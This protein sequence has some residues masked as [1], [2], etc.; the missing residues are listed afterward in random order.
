MKNYLQTIGLH[1]AV[2]VRRAITVLLLL[3]AGFM[4]PGLVKASDFLVMGW[5][6]INY[7]NNLSL[8]G[9]GGSAVVTIKWSGW[10]L[11]T[12]SH[13]TGNPNYICGFYSNQYYRNWF[14]FDIPTGLGTITSATLNVVQYGGIP[15]SGYVTIQFYDVTTPYATVNTNYSGGSA[16]GQAIFADLGTGAYFGNGLIDNSLPQSNMVSLPLNAAA[17][18]SIQNAAGTTWMVA[19]RADNISPT[20]PPDAVT[21]SATNVTGSSATFNGSVNANGTSTATYFRYGTVSGSLGTEVTASP[22]TVTGSSA[23]AISY[24][25]TGLAAGTTYYYQVKAYAASISSTVY[26]LEKSFTT[27]NSTPPAP[28]S[29]ISV[30]A[31]PICNGGG[32]TLT[33]NGPVGT[34]YWY[35]GGT[36]GG[37]SIGQGNTLT[38]YPTTT[39]TYSAMN[40]NNSLFS[41]CTASAAVVVNNP[42]TVPATATCGSV[43]NTTAALSWGTSTATGAITYYWVVGTSSSVTYGTVGVAGVAAQGTT[44][45][46][47]TTATATGLSPST[48]Y[49]LRVYATTAA[50]CGNSAYQTSTAF[51]TVPTAPVASGATLIRANSFTANWATTTG[52]TSYFLDVS[53]DLNFGSFLTGYNNR[54]VGNVTSLGLSGLNRETTYY[55]RVRGYNTGGYSLYSSTITVLTLPVN[56]FLIENP[57][58]GNVTDQTAGI[59]FPVKI[60]ARDAFNTTVTDYTGNATLTTNSVISSGATTANFVAGVLS[61]TTLTLTLAGTMKTITATSGPVSTASNPFTVLPAAINYFGLVA[62][63][64]VTAGT[65]F[66]VT[67]TVYDVYNNVKTNYSGAH[68]VTWTTTATTSLSGQG[69]IIPT[70][71]DQTFTN[72]V[73]TIGGSIIGGFTFY[74]SMETPTITITD[75]PTSSP[76]TT[77]PITILDAGLDNFK[78]VA[79]V[80]QQ[81]GV[82]FDVTV[83]ARDIYWNTCIYYVGNIR[84]KSSNDAV[85]DFPAGLQPFAPADHG[86]RDFSGGVTINA[87]GAYW[88]RA[89]DGVYAY[90]SGQQENIVVGPGPFSKLVA[91]STL[92]I[93]PGENHPAIDDPI[94][95]VAGQYVFVTATPRDALGNLMYACRDISILLNGQPTDNTGPIVVTNVGDGS[96]TATVR[97]TLSGTNTISARYNTT[98]TLFDQTRTVIVTP[99]PIDLAH[100]TITASPTTMTTDGTSSIIVQLKDQFDNNR[101]TSD[102]SVALATTKGWLSAVTDNSNGTYSSTLH[103]NFGAVG[104]AHITGNFTGNSLNLTIN[105]PFSNSADVLINE[106]LP[107]LATIDISANPTVITTNQ[108]SLISVQLKDQFG[109]LVTTNRG[110]VTLASDKGALTAVAYTSGG[111]YTSTLSGWNPGFGTATIT[112]KYNGG[113]IADNATVTFNPGK[114][115]LAHITVSAN[116]ITMTS[117]ES[118]VITVQLKD[119]YDNIITTSRGTITL[120]SDKGA[121]T[122]VTDHGDGTYTATLTG[123]NRGFGTATITAHLVDAPDVINGDVTHHATVNITEGKPNLAHIDISPSVSSMTSDQTALITVQLKDQFGN[124]LSASRGTITLGTTLGALT[125]VTDHSNGTYTATLF[126]KHQRLRPCHHHRQPH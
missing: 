8:V 88:V 93:A 101:T 1:R 5:S 116:P 31:N 33:A 85:V 107:A 89:A 91:N 17:R 117:D 121:L 15:S 71:G 41:T 90:K 44:S 2:A 50:P 60:T 104:T 43:T 95:R 14:A 75:A 35:S 63:G 26:G 13:S 118:S 87:I 6:N 48:T 61:S 22:A 47:T 102:G 81:T 9:T 82:P 37:T 99:A 106:G 56:N 20:L 78:V 67:A 98:M 103:G 83:T 51:T 23:T 38:V 4:Q 119:V 57:S 84:F 21:N 115:D 10:Y 92:T 108:T 76:G 11:E 120:T 96:Y 49:Y 40:Y 124:N 105:G 25:V 80:T 100:T 111:I 109:N 34:V 46:P 28:P 59:A 74:N 19:G 65:P 126:G 94:Y 79:G 86:V 7:S 12:G 97:A 69:R 122:A 24:N 39:T 45:A 30:S 36:C 62:N 123:D 55:Y 114:P 113:D 27:A 77:A 73:A 3:L 70:D 53:T 110:T 32:T 29:S 54:N 18:G 16:T 72:G 66:T 68:S 52:A 112:G 42:A 64:P 125:S 58:G